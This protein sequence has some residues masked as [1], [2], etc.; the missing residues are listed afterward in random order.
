MSI[1]RAY[2]AHQTLYCSSRADS[3]SKHIRPFAARAFPS[4]SAAPA[5]ANPPVPPAGRGLSDNVGLVPA[6]LGIKVAGLAVLVY[7]LAAFGSAVNIG[8][9]GANAMVASRAVVSNTNGQAAVCTDAQ[10]ME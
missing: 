8:T 6:S 5:A 7:A 2:E 4:P 1:L 3:P 9:V 10:G